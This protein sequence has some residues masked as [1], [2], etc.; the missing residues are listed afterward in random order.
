L[1]DGTT[2]LILQN[3]F[4]ANQY[5]FDK[6]WFVGWMPGQMHLI[7]FFTMGLV[8]ELFCQALPTHNV[9][10]MCRFPLEGTSATRLQAQ[11]AL[12]WLAKLA[13]MDQ[14]SNLCSRKI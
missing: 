7:L 3:V 1:K 14:R 4:I 2:T 12:N 6:L 10:P 13:E 11:M 5:L 8:A 9:S